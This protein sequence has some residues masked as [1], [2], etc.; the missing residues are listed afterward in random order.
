MLMDVSGF[1]STMNIAMNLY[2]YV[3]FV[4]TSVLSGLWFHSGVEPLGCMGTLLF[5]RGTAKHSS[6]DGA[7]FVSHQE[8]P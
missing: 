2:L 6:K 4:W 5:I 1:L 7:P 8:C 3:S